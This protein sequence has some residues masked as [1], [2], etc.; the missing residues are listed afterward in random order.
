MRVDASFR[1]FL[2][3]GTILLVSVWLRFADLGKQGLFFDE[4]WSWAATRLRWPALLRLSLSDP[5][6][7]LYYILLKLYLFVFPSSEFG[8]RALSASFS[9]ASLAAVLVYV[10]SRWNTE[11]MLYVG[12]LMALSPFDI[13]YSQETRMYTLLGFLWVSSYISLVKT[14]EGDRKFLIV[15][16]ITIILMAWTHICGV[17]VAFTHLTFIVSYLLLKSRLKVWRHL[18]CDGRHLVVG[19]ASIVLG[20]L[21]PLALSFI[22]SARGAGGA[23][24]PAAKDLL[25]LFLLWM[26]G[27][28][29]VRDYF[30][31]GAHLVLPSLAVLSTTTWLVIGM[32]TCGFPALWGMHHTWRIKSRRQVEILLAIML[33]IVPIALVFGYGVITAQGVWA[34]KPFLGSAY[35]FYIWAGVG[36]GSIKVPL[37]RKCVAVAIAVVAIMSLWP[38]YTTWRKST[39]ASAFHSLPALAGQEGVIVEPSYLSPLVFYY[40]GKTVPAYGIV[41]KQGDQLSLIRILPTDTEVLGLRQRITCAELSSTTDLWVYDYN[42]RTRDAMQNWPDCVTTKRLWVFQE[43][44]WRQLGP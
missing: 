10:R 5:H 40:V 32:A 30:L 1:R 39:A 20:T 16:P 15:W 21:P 14:L 31:D 9:I 41:A 11:T 6:P 17:I 8:L 37:L 43:N 12:L 34:L 7:P 33:I 27:L 29:P 42:N 35:L 25:V 3:L 2:T 4:A 22:H 28:T 26:T 13:Y 44:Q 36:I 38:Y 24:M 18:V 19:A 23:W